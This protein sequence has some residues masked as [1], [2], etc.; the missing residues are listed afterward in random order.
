MIIMQYLY[1]R[2]FVARS[3][4]ARSP[5]VDQRLTCTN[6]WAESA[7]RS[8]GFYS[9]WIFQTER[10]ICCDEP[11]KRG[12]PRTR[13]CSTTNIIGDERRTINRKRELWSPRTRT[14]AQNGAENDGGCRSDGTRGANGRSQHE[15]F[16][17]CNKNVH[18]PSQSPKWEVFPCSTSCSKGSLWWKN[19]SR[20]IHQQT[21]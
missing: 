8:K 2:V 10:L 12:S 21:T 18:L 13:H 1:I 9:D 14:E 4:W 16:Y 17:Y 19:S 5:V 6:A 7:V 3:R 15:E 20:N 11:T